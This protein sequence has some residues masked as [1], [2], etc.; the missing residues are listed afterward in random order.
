M[1][2]AFNAAD[3]VGHGIVVFEDCYRDFDANGE[4]EHAELVAQH[5]DIDD[6]GQTVDVRDVGASNTFIDTVLSKTGVSGIALPLLVV[7]ITVSSTC[8]AATVSIRR[9]AKRMDMGR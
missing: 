8:V 6:L 5:A 7:A 1:E 2:F 4:F 3:L 9:R